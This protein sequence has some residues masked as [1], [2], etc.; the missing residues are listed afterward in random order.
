M[1]W[2]RLAVVVVFRGAMEATED[3]TTIEADGSVEHTVVVGRNG[4]KTDPLAS[5]RGKVGFS[6]LPTIFPFPGNL[7]AVAAADTAAAAL[8]AWCLAALCLS[9][10]RRAGPRRLTRLS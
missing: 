5:G 3:V 2:V 9:L 7:G 4:G 10:S 1:G 8:A 6:A